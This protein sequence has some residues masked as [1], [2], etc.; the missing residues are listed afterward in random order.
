MTQPFEWDSGLL[1]TNTVDFDRAL[2]RLRRIGAAGIDPALI[3]DLASRLRKQPGLTQREF[4]RRFRLVV[5]AIVG[6]D[7][8]ALQEVAAHL[9]RTSPETLNALRTL[10]PAGLRHIA[11]LPRANAKGAVIPVVDMTSTALPIEERTTDSDQVPGPSKYRAVALI[12]TPEEHVRNE[13]LLKKDDLDPLRIPT[14]DSLWDLAST[15][16]CGFV[17]GGSIWKQVPAAEHYEIVRRI[18]EH[19][20]F[21]FIRISIY[22]I[23]STIAQDFTQA[24]VHARCGPLDGQRFCHG[25]DC[26]LTPSDISE[27]KST[28]RLLESAATT[29]FFPLGLSETEASLLRLIAADRRRPM[30]SLIVPRLGTR[31]LAGGRSGA[32]VF[33]LDDGSAQPFVAKVGKDELLKT[34]VQ[35]YQEWIE[36]WETSVTNPRFH[37][38]LGS[39]AISYRLQ[40]A[41]DGDGT[42]A[43]T[44]EDSLE[45]LRLAEWGDPPELSTQMAS[46]IFRAIAWAADRLANLNSLPGSGAGGEEFWLDWP[47]ENLA[48]RGID[49]TLVDDN[50]RTL[51][52][53][54]LVQE[55]MS[56][57]R[58][59]LVRGV[60]HGDIHGRNILLRDRLPVFIDFASSGP[61]HPLVDLVRLDAVVRAAAMRMLLDKQSMRNIIRAIYIDGTAAD[62]IL[63]EHSVIAASPLAALAVRTAAKVREK[64]TGVMK[65]HG[66]GLS[67]FWAMN[68][69]VAAHVLANRS[70]G[71][72]IERLVLSVIGP[73][74]LADRGR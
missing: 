33:L 70:P 25:Q 69:V 67:D 52:L 19:S 74:F 71:S 28:A 3:S 36:N 38:H 2:N 57:L 58:P 64:A 16:L 18:C 31:E 15:G 63:S 42:P 53:K 8:A 49:F 73:R 22:G 12:G 50:W 14:L 30:G 65:E 51:G 29:D 59:N 35:R 41:P 27:L 34:E 20:T 26:E 7:S 46:D 61:G 56:C 9:R 39:A 5:A 45:R 13:A 44:L 17:V 54:E 43:P 66:L 11:T 37:F 6:N 10:L 32:R 23:D 4:D 48:K 60:V 55:A 72:G 21:L 40:A 68:C 62:P 1:A 47:V 24:A